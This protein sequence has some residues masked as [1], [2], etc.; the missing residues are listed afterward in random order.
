MLRSLSRDAALTDPVFDAKQHFTQPPARYTEAVLVRTMEACGIGRPSTYAPTLATLQDRHYVRKENRNL[1]V[2]ELGEA[3]DQLTVQA[4]PMLADKDFTAEMEGELDQV[5]EGK[6]QWQEILREFYPPFK[7]KLD[8]ASASLEKV[9]VQDEVSDV[10]CSKC[11]RLMVYKYGARGRFLACPGFPEC[12]NTQSIEV[13]AGWPCPK[14]GS[15]VLILRTKRGKR[16]YGCS[17][18]DCDYMA[19]N[20]PAR[21]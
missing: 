16:F 19:W 1:L 8:E 3:V 21:S 15:P 17:N 9:K 6:R 11:G 20:P 2:T 4:V 14:C 5:A 18:K 13:R 7:A 10:V 12:R